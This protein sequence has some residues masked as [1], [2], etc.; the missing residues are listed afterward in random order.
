MRIPTASKNSIIVLANHFNSPLLYLLTRVWNK[1][2]TVFG[3]PLL[4]RQR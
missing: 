1:C 4:G 3:C 2:D